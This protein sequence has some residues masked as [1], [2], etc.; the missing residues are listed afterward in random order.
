MGDSV[1]TSALPMKTVETV[2]RVSA[3]I[4]FLLLVVGWAS[5]CHAQNGIKPDLVWSSPGWAGAAP[6]TTLG[7]AGSNGFHLKLD[8]GR[9]WSAAIATLLVD[10]QV[11]P[12]LAVNVTSLSPGAG[13]VIKLDDKPYDVAH[14]HELVPVPAGGNSPG[15]YLL[16]LS[17]LSG[18]AWQGRKQLDIRLFVTGPPGASVAFS[19]IELLPV[20][21]VSSSK[22]ADQGSKSAG[23][24][25]ASRGFLFGEWVMRYDTAKRR[26][27][28]LRAD[29][30]GAG[31]I[32]IFLPGITNGTTPVVVD[33]AQGRDKTARRAGFTLR[34]ATDVADYEA[35]VTASA[36][37]GTGN[38][39]PKATLFRWTVT[40]RLRKTVAAPDLRLVASHA[41]VECLYEPPNGFSDSSLPLRVLSQHRFGQLGQETG[42]A[43]LPCDPVLGGGLYVQNLTALAPLFDAT[44][45]SG[46]KSV[47]AGPEGFG[48]SPSPVALPPAAQA[49]AD[50]AQLPA[51]TTL[52]LADSFLALDAGDSAF[53]A[54]PLP[55]SRQYI[56]LLATIY[57][58]LPNRP[59]TV[60]SDWSALAERALT[61]LQSLACWSNPQ[62]GYLRNY[63]NEPWGPN[64]GELT[65]QLAPLVASLLYE[66]ARNLPQ[67]ALTKRI[68]PTLADFY[69][70]ETRSIHDYTTDPRPARADSE[71]QVGSLMLLAQAAELG[72]PQA[73]SLLRDSLDATIALARRHQYRFPVFFDP[74]TLDLIGGI[75]PDCSGVYAYLMLQCY[76]LFGDSSYLEEARKALAVIDDFGMGYGYELHGTAT[77]AV[78]CAQMWKITGDRSYLDKSLLPL[79]N[80]LRHCWLYEPDYG[81]RKGEHHFF[82]VS[83]MPG[84]YAAP[85]EQ[86]QAWL[87]LREYDDLVH[88]DLPASARLLLGEFL[89]YGPTNILFLYPTYLTPGSIAPAS[90]RGGKLEP[91]LLVPIEDLYDPWLISGKIGQEVYGA[92]GPLAVAARTVSTIP[93]AGLTVASEYPIR[94]QVWNAQRHILRLRLAGFADKNS[95]SGRYTTRVTLRYDAAKAGWSGSTSDKATTSRPAPKRLRIQVVAGTGQITDRRDDPGYLSFQV[96]GGT[97]LLIDT[98]PTPAVIPR[99]KK[100]K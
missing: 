32:S 84:I 17:E 78:A 40:A 76:R 38:S 100:G 7:S 61:D 99:G 35:R 50:A 29:S 27:R 5:V 25:D 8:K 60:E 83:A 9:A 16:D 79:A 41:E 55:Q 36:P 21:A 93:E 80:V 15:R 87:L 31:A 98:A 81:F 39:G 53:A 72:L 94:E 88:D 73:K 89:R 70:P 14:P 91:D 77:G 33:A 66:R 3:K 22:S 1:I 95:Y 46:T 10:L 23:R 63:V 52:T 65:V 90:E 47:S 30:G 62:S 96:E 56:D 19:Q 34:T 59:T 97:T 57:D 48:F 71:T 42:Q 68:A 64:T 54:A 58:A 69:S 4:A 26:L 20:M 49:E 44:H 82:T 12:I 6:V 37:Q 28:I 43:F 51:G 13:W 85:A 24:T 74:K 11:T 75:E 2:C 92:G 45:T 86:Y 18:A 67:T